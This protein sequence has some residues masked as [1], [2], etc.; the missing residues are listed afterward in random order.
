MVPVPSIRP[1][2]GSCLHGHRNTWP[3]T[4]VETHLSETR[5]VADF[6]RDDV[7]EQTSVHA[8]RRIILRNLPALLRI[9]NVTA[10]GAEGCGNLFGQCGFRRES[11]RQGVGGCRSSVC[12]AAAKK[13]LSLAGIASG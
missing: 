6:T 1:V 2:A 7:D 12:I 8:E 10:S 5:P 3:T 11:A 9:A 13:M 4:Q